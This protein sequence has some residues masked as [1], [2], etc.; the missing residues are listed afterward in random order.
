M[1]IFL[2]VGLCGIASLASAQD[3]QLSDDELNRL[4][5]WHPAYKPQTPQ[6]QEYFKKYSS[7][8][9]YETIGELAD[10][11]AQKKDT[12]Q[13][14]QINVAVLQR[15]GVER[16]AE[17]KEVR[18]LNLDVD[19]A[20]ATG[21]LWRAVGQLKRLQRL[22]IV[23]VSADPRPVLPTFSLGLP[24]E[25]RQ[26]TNLAQ[27]ELVL[28][29][30]DWAQSLATLAGMPA[31]RKLTL[32]G[33]GH[34]ATLPLEIG[35]VRQLTSLTIRSG[36]NAVRI[37]TSLGELTALKELHMNYL[38]SDQATDWTFLSKLTELET[39]QLSGT[40]LN[41]LPGLQNH[42]K[43]RSLELQG[44]E[45]LTLS[46]DTFEG[47]TALEK[48][49]LTNCKLRQFPASLARIGGLKEL[50]L[51]YN[52]LGELPDSFGALKQLEVLQL[53]SCQLQKLPA[54]MGELSRLR[55]LD[56]SNNQL[57]TLRFSFDNL[58]GLTSLSL[59]NNQL[60]YLP[61]SLGRL[62]VLDQL[63]VSNNKLVQ[64]P[65]TL[66]DLANLSNLSL[67][68]NQ[69]TRL[70]A[71]IGRLRKLRH[72]EVTQN[73][74]QQL[75]AEIGQL[76]RLNQLNLSANQLTALP[77]AFGN[78]DSL[79]MLDLSR[80]QLTAAPGFLFRLTALQSLNL[81]ENK[82]S[83]L[84]NELGKL[85]RL[86]YLVLA[87]NRLISLPPELGKL[88]RLQTLLISDNPLELLP[89]TVAQC[90]DL[91]SMYARNTKLR[92]LPDGITKL[93]RLQEVDLSGNELTILPTK[94][95]NLTEL[96]SLRLGRTRL[97]AL[98]E[99][100]GRLTK[101]N[102]LQ[103]GELENVVTTEYAGLHQ[104]PDSIVYC[105]D[106]TTVQLANQ[107]GLDGDDT[108]AKVSQ[109]KKLMN[110]T[111]FR[112]NLERLP[113][114][115]WK[116]FPV[117]QLSLMRNRL[118]ELPVSMLESPRLQQIG[119][120][121]NLLPKPLNTNFG[122]KEALRLAFSEAGLL[123]LNQIAKP[124]R[125]VAQAYAQK[126][127]QMAGQR[128]WTEAFASFEKAI[129]YASD[130]LRVVL[131]AQRADMHVFRQEYKE[132]IADYDQSILLAN[133]LTKGVSSQ[134]PFQKLQFDQP[135]VLALRGRA[136][137]KAKLGQIEAAAA[138][139]DLAIQRITE[140]RGD[141]QLIGSL[142]IEQGR[143]RTLKNN[144]QEANASYRKAIEEYE[145]QPYANVAIKLTVV[146]LHLLVGQPDQARK[147]LQQIDKRELIRGNAT[148]EKY[149][150]G[151]IQVLKS[152]KPDA[153]VLAELSQYVSTHSD[154]ILGW[155]FELYENWLPRSGLPMEK[156]AVLQ[157][158]TQLTQERLPKMD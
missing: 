67:G 92:M 107:F 25:L 34:L 145:K 7:P 17:L 82:L 108:F 8:T 85:T 156:Q 51:S 47:L 136:H 65:E 84:P 39:L 157:Q 152:E 119:L 52:L 68:M 114:M 18:R 37:P 154:L 15:G 56:L 121:E 27:L 153:D 31:L 110:L 45:Q 122:S 128:N 137:A 53:S 106:L 22:T 102:T 130:T 112:C 138:D 116:N 46:E 57:D 89:E 87:N 1:R 20:T 40:N 42:K 49:N 10:R 95:G 11:I 21:T 105:Q 70:P 60:R 29:Q 129:E 5:I 150:E 63:N 81:M 2:L 104:L 16:L 109:L 48:V 115:D 149:L 91:V 155:S 103:I 78:L 12:V 148:L 101:L 13:A 143:Y 76:R 77:E 151:T 86:T 41:R 100:I 35:K 96:R 125:N 44:N 93:P 123:A 58:T 126:A 99:S 6:E 55:M 88:A 32:A 59:F 14:L 43:L 72:L 83:A 28:H 144:V 38:Q 62:T 50:Q 24:A 142:W 124:N 26:L 36:G 111:L 139:I 79:Q 135:A 19:S 146:E 117:F 94:L 158:L 30:A 64:V 97:L 127:F 33:N 134:Q 9:A 80:N 4:R 147:A 66:G 74:L 131:F 71:G 75:P 73:Q 3:R 98:P 118:S 133:R 141:P 132:A 120:F 54:S 113:E 61:P 90:R 23:Q 69:L 140:I